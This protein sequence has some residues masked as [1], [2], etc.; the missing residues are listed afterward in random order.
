[1][2]M[3]CHTTTICSDLGE[4][5]IM[6]MTLKNGIFSK[7][8]FDSSGA[9]YFGEV[10][11][12]SCPKPPLVNFINAR[13][14]LPTGVSACNNS[15]F[16]CVANCQL[17]GATAGIID[18]SIINFSITETSPSLG[19]FL[20]SSDTN[21]EVISNNSIRIINA[22]L[23]TG[24]FSFNIIFNP[25]GQGYCINKTVTC[26]VSSFG[27]LSPGYGLGT[28]TGGSLVYTN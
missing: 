24:L 15:I 17:T 11:Y 2:S 14:D 27:D 5:I 1:M 25:S 12:P 19:W 18:G 8:F 9:E 4:T 22:S 20:Y 21:I 28:N 26:S 16:S 6:R 13:V 3:C 10:I 23:F 7:K